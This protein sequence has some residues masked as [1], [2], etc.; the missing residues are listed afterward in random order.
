MGNDLYKDFYEYC[1]SEECQALL[2]QY[3]QEL[4]E[5]EEYCDPYN[6]GIPQGGNGYGMSP[7]KLNQ[8]SPISVILP[9]EGKY[10]NTEMVR[11]HETVD[12]IYIDDRTY[13]SILTQQGCFSKM[14]VNKTTVIAYITIKNAKK[15]HLDVGYGQ[16]YLIHIDGIAT[17]PQT[18]NTTE[19]SFAIMQEHYEKN[20]TFDLFKQAGLTHFFTLKSDV[21]VKKALSIY[22]SQKLEGVEPIGTIPYHAG[23]FFIDETPKFIAKGADNTEFSKV[24]SNR[25][26]ARNSFPLADV[27]VS[28][29]MEL[30]HQ[31]DD[32]ITSLFLHVVRWASM[33]TSILERNELKQRS[34]LSV[35]GSV[36]EVGSYLCVF[37]RTEEHSH[38]CQLEQ[39]VSK[40]KKAIFEHQ[41]EVLLM[42]DKSASVIPQLLSHS[43]KEKAKEVLNLIH[44]LFVMN[45]LYD[46]DEQITN[47]KVH[48]TCAFINGYGD[49]MLPSDSVIR[50]C[51]PKL[52]NKNIKEQLEVY[53]AFDSLILDMVEQHYEKVKDKLCSYRINAAFNA[54]WRNKG[55]NN[56]QKS[57]YETWYATFSLITDMIAVLPVSSDDFSEYLFGLF[58]TSNEYSDKEYLVQKVGERISQII[59]NGEANIINDHKLFH[60]APSEEKA[61]VYLKNGVLYFRNRDFK[62]LITSK[63]SGRVNDLEVKK[64]LDEAGYLETEGNGYEMKIKLTLAMGQVRYVA[65][66]TSL[67][68]DHVCKQL[69]YLYSTFVPCQDDGSICRVP[70]GLDEKEKQLYWS[71]G[72][73]DLNNLAMLVTGAPGNGKN[74][75]VLR[76]AIELSKKKRNV[77]FIDYTGSCAPDELVKIGVSE[78]WIAENVC[79]VHPMERCD[80]ALSSGKI[81]VYSIDPQKPL[82]DIKACTDRLLCELTGWCEAVEE[83][84]VHIV[85]DEAHMANLG[86]DSVIA[87]TLNLKR[88]RGVS[89]ILIAP[90]YNNCKV[91]ERTVLGSVSTKVIF[92][93]STLKEAEFSAKEIG[94]GCERE[95]SRQVMSMKKGTCLVVGFLEDSDGELKRGLIRIHNEKIK[96]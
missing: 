30:L 32:T 20:R 90:I 42:V 61:S 34:I 38:I 96:M 89:L 15:Y 68:A 92:G 47:Q 22:I 60:V 88:K 77:V 29:F 40:I 14:P 35:I 55:L 4:R 23:F 37:G 27:K 81:V 80:T 1:K 73:Q 72:H 26:F 36:E 83:R 18:G 75:F 67:L 48:C 11:V 51:A 84:Q 13:E 6:N 62:E 9:P 66:H 41:D 78:Q 86:E 46:L 45:N 85:I 12:R 50:V 44:E 2:E 58:Y 69:P 70:L 71:V 8:P 33:L 82:D 94:M 31:S 63:I 53:E 39:S 3:M 17:S 21:V 16:D 28:R 91:K 54:F 52:R 10:Q 19:F 25:S 74:T 43:Q 24:I 79:Y 49:E 95:L 76:L 87:T 64:A 7:V 57:S 65:V 5:R 93:T 56:K 59:F